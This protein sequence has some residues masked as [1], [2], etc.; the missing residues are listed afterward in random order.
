[1]SKFIHIVKLERGGYALRMEQEIRRWG[2]LRSSWYNNAVGKWQ[3]LFGSVCVIDQLN[4]AIRTAR[5]MAELHG[6]KVK[7][8]YL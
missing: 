7:Y 5:L 3:R 8:D 6:A 2:R 4:D 1:M